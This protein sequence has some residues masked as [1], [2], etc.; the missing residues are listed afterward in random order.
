M[1][2]GFKITYENVG[3]VQMTFLRLLSKE[4][5]QNFTYN[6]I[7]S[8]AWFYQSTKSFDFAVKFHGQNN[9]E[10]SHRSIN[11]PKVL[12]DGCK[13]MYIFKLIFL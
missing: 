13:V 1:R 3:S 2:N 12:Y 6:C 9:H 11:K 7:N 8:A 5:Y 10:F 4:A